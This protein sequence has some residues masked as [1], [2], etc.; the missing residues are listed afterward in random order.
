[1]GEPE[2]IGAAVIDFAA[3]AARMRGMARPAHEIAEWQQG[4][5]KPARLR[6]SIATHAE[7]ESVH[8]TAAVQSA[9]AIVP[10]AWSREGI[11]WARKWL[12]S[13][14]GAIV[15]GQV[16]SGKSTLLARLLL[17]LGIPTAASPA[18]EGY[19]VCLC[20]L[21]RLVSTLAEAEFRGGYGKLL[22]AIG[23]V[24]VL[25]LDDVGVGVLRRGT[26]QHLWALLDARWSTRRPVLA[27]SN[28]DP[29]ADR[30][31]GQRCHAEDERAMERAFDRLHALAP[32]R[33]RY[34]SD[35]SR[36]DGAK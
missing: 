3:M 10:D 20:S 16:G 23:A 5:E 26:A 9:G 25:V 36:R 1:M 22:G 6:Q 17:R 11:E 2:N 30:M 24:D 14:P 28:I 35:K 19:S 18:G 27:T 21:P 32:T 29:A 34:D 15:W 12:P 31:L 33:I 8:D 4:R 13:Q 7:I